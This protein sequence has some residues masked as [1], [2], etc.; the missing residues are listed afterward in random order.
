MKVQIYP[1]QLINLGK[2]A[3]E[4]GTQNAWIDLATEWIEQAN[5]KINELLKEVKE[6]G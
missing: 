4:A 3:K 6:D 5:K 1:E 2:I